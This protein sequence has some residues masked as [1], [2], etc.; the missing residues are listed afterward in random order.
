MGIKP[1]VWTVHLNEFPD[2]VR[3][4]KPFLPHFEV[5][6]GQRRRAHNADISVYFLK[7]SPQTKEAFGFEQELLLVYSPYN[8]LQP[9]SI[10]AAEQAL[11]EDRAKGRVERL[12]YFLVSEMPGT[13]KWVE[14]YVARNQ[15]ARLIAAFATDDLAR[16]EKDYWYVWNQLADQFFGRDLFDF[17]LPLEHDTYF[18]GRESEVLAYRDAIKRGENRG[19]FGLRKTGKTSLLFKVERLLKAENAGEVVYL[20]CKGPDVRT[21][22]WHELLAVLCQRIDPSIDAEALG[23]KSGAAIAQSFVRVIE[24]ATRSRR[25]VLVFDEIEFISPLAKLDE[26]WKQDFIAFWQTIWSC[27][28]RHRGLS[29]IIAGV[30]PT[31]TE[32]STYNGVQNPLFGIV[33]PQYLKGFSISETTRMVRSL[34]RRM[35]MKFKEDAT[36]YLQ[37]H[38]GGHPLLTRMACSLTNS[39]IQRQRLK[40]PVNINREMLTQVELVRDSD[41]AYYCEH[42]VSEL[43]EFY[44]DE[45]LMLELLAGK[46]ISDYLTLAKDPSLVKHLREYGLL[47]ETAGYPKISI[48]VIDR[49]VSGR[50]GGFSIV[51]EEARSAWVQQRVNSVLHDLRALERRIDALGLPSLFGPN[52]FSESEKFVTLGV[53]IDAASFDVFINTLNRCLVES[54]EKFGEYEQKEKYFWSLRSSYPSLHFALDRIKTYRNSSMHL[55]LTPSVEEKLQN[56]LREDLQ[57]R[58]PSEVPDGWFILQ[59]R[60][61]DELFASLQVEFVNLNS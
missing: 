40:R 44:P 39:L 4:L 60:V 32:V 36:E 29:A 46:S 51:E 11:Y 8:E 56:Y 26:H 57:G 38:Y 34:G 58:W 13:R 48:P 47:T 42:V 2:E 55:S 54:I 16:Y 21:L 15:E 33:S 12:A 43:R 41:L 28:S 49:Y 30:N 6:W 61:L 35:G 53:V 20:D 59:Q 5:T 1:E 14:D 37:S 9:R 7:P 31:V 52:S 50:A 22:R 27:Q 25:Y 3:V 23:T 18:F 19:L 24:K 10:K 17:R 45:Y